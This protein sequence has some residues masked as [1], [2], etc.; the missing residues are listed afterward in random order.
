MIQN[1][2]KR[3]QI[4]ELKLYIQQNDYIVYLYTNIILFIGYLLKYIK[5]FLTETFIS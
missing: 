3:K 5:I 4:T 2:H 1:L